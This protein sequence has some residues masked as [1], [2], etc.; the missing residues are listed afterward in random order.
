MVRREIALGERMHSFG[1]VL[2]GDLPELKWLEFINAV[3]AAIGMEPV[4][5][6]KV[7]TYPF[8][9]KGGTGQTIFLPITES[10]LA[11]DTWKDHTGAYLFVCSCRPFHSKD[12]DDVA[13]KSGLKVDLS[14]AR[15]FYHELNLK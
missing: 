6:P 12:I 4:C 7:F 10:F 13:V 2:L 9:G 8:E 1:C 5:E 11:L 14:N 3:C 15:R